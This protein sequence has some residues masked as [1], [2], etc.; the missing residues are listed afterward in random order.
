MKL[1]KIGVVKSYRKW[2]IYHQNREKSQKCPTF[3]N[4]E[5]EERGREGERDDNTWARGDMQFLLEY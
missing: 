3:L 4:G 1:C 2:L 5:R